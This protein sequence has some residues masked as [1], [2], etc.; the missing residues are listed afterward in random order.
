MYQ[1]ISFIYE[2]RRRAIDFL[3]MFEWLH[4]TG[5]YNWHKEPPRSDNLLM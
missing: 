4:N 5:G 1:E 3:S 2:E